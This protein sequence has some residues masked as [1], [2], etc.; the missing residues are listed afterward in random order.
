MIETE[1]PETAR[2]DAREGRRGVHLD[3]EWHRTSLHRTGHC[4]EQAIAAFRLAQDAETDRYDPAD[5]SREVKQRHCRTGL[6]FQLDLAE[7]RFAVGSDNPSYIQDDFHRAVA[8]RHIPAVPFDVN[9]EQ[10][11]QAGTDPDKQ[12]L[13]LWIVQLRLITCDRPFPFF[14]V[15]KPGHDAAAGF[16]RLYPFISRLPDAQRHAAL[17]QIPAGRV[18]IDGFQLQDRGGGFE[19]I[20]LQERHRTRL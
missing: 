6:H 2:R 15:E 5:S 12:R 9:L 18:E 14:T 19:R 1:L 20:F 13:D 3:R 16:D 7:R 17:G 11:R 4:T 8:F 10:G